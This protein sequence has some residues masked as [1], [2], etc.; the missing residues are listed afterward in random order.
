MDSTAHYAKIAEIL[1]TKSKRE[2]ARYWARADPKGTIKPIFDQVMGKYALMPID[3]PR[4][5]LDAT[6]KD[7]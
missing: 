3:D 1:A 7:R 5:W 4:V 6:A 2:R